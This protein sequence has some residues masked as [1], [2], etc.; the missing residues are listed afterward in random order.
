MVG[1][2]SVS[3]LPQRLAATADESQWEQLARAVGFC[4]RGPKK[5]RPLAF[6][7]GLCLWA[8]QSAVSYRLAAAFIG[9][10]AHTT[11]SKQAVAKR[12]TPAAVACV[13]AAL[14]RVLARLAQQTARVTPVVFA[15]FR[16]VLV[17]DSTAVALAGHLAAAFP[18]NANGRGQPLAVLKIQC[19]FD[20]VAEQFVQWRLTSFRVNDQAAA[21][22]ILTVAQ[23][24]DLVLRDL[25]YF[26]LTALTALRARGAAF[27]S[28]LRVG[29]TVFTP[30][31]EPL[32][33]LGVLR[34]EG[35]LDRWVRLGQT[36]QL[37]VRLVAVP[38]SA[39]VANER[40]RKAEQN[41]DRRHPPS[42]ARLLLLGW[43]LFITSVEAE[44]W[45]AE[46]VCRVY[47][48][49]WRIEI[50]FKSWKSH[51]HLGAM[52]AGGAVA[53]EL[54]VW[55]RL[56]LVTLLHGWLAAEL[57]AGGTLSLLKLA[58]WWALCGPVLLLGPL[59]V[60]FAARWAVQARY[61]C[62]YEHRRKRMNFE[63]KLNM[64]G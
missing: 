18:G 30:T 24:G 28:R 3:A 54:L 37:P 20:V 17:Q 8:S 36:E 14:A 34:R 51:F 27:L 42:K 2:V 5:I 32:D 4:Q 64:L 46:T 39:A 22:E 47:G 13:R 40:R 61:H 62:R 19:V 38:V 57:A 44:V 35:T 23:R 25:G 53:V 63:E 33:L 41:R 16:R 60:E 7:H 9:L 11:V 12:F 43:D 50:V 52:G 21:P 58:Q 49:R 15:T 48:V 6:L 56:L 55:A 26:A 10:C 31:G 59:V 45:S 29:T 1:L